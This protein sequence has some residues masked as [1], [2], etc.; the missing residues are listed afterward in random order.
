MGLA[1]LGSCWKKAR[2]QL[3]WRKAAKYRHG[4]GVEEGLDLTLT[5]KQYNWYIKHG[6]VPQ[7]GASMT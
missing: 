5:T 7:A 1:S 4:R 6:K 3:L 2:I